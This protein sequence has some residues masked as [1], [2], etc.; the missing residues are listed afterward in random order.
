MTDH[1]QRLAAVVPVFVEAGCEGPK[2]YHTAQGWRVRY[3]DVFTRSVGEGIAVLKEWFNE[4]VVPWAED[5]GKA[6][7]CVPSRTKKSGWKW[8]VY[9]EHDIWYRKGSD[10]DPTEAFTQCAEALAKVIGGE[11]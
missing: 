9:N 10:P 11:G 1:L 7:V 8:T 6:F 2:M 4:T 5:E 3:K